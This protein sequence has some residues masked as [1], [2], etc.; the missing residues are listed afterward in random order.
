[1]C[2]VPDPS[3]FLTK[4]IYFGSN[5]IS[6]VYFLGNYNFDFSIKFLIESVTFVGKHTSRKSLILNLASES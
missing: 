1:M 6:K 3:N 4:N 5:S 2:Q